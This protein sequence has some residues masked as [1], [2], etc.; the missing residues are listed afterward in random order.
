MPSTRESPTKINIPSKA[1][2]RCGFRSPIK[3]LA[4]K[5]C[6]GLFKRARA[7][8]PP[9][10]LDAISAASLLIKLHVEYHASGWRPCLAEQWA[11]LALQFAPAPTRARA[12]RRAAHTRGL[13]T[14]RSVQQ[15]LRDDS[16]YETTMTRC[17]DYANAFGRCGVLALYRL[18]PGIPT[19]AMDGVTHD[20][21]AHIE[22]LLCAV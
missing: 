15:T 5:R 1:C 4:C 11:A 22:R 9:I 7:E 10:G 21:A 18:L 12:R 17:R 3:C 2:R 19:G 20:F 16:L 6:H 13:Q 8:P 14:L